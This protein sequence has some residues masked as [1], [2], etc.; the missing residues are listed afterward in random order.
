VTDV[1]TIAVS[2]RT[3]L[4]AG[5]AG[6][7]ALGLGLCRLEEK[8]KPALAPGEPAPPLV[9]DGL[10]DL[11]REKWSW[12]SVVHSSHARANCISTCSWNVFVKNGI[13]WR[14]EQNAIYEASEPGVP[15]FNPRGCQKGACYTHLM[16]EASRVTHPLRRVGERG[17]GRWKR[18]SWNEALTETADAI[19]DASVKSGTGAVVYDHGTT[20]IDFGPDTVGEMR[21]FRSL[22]ATVIDS[23]AGVGDMP[24]GAVQTWGMYNCEGTSDDWFKSDFIVVWVGNPAYTRI[25]EVHFK[26][27]ARYRGA[28][29]AVIAPDYNAS[30]VHA[31]YWLNPKVGTD[32]A[33]ALAMAQVILRES[34]HDVEYV[35]EQ[36]DLP[37][38]IREDTGRYLRE[39]DLKRNGNDEVLYFWDEAKDRLAKVP[40]AQGEGGRSLALGAL[41]PA[42]SGRRKVK[43]AD[44]S[45]VWVRPLLERMREHLDAEYTPEQSAAISGVSAG[46]IERIA[47]ELAAAGSAMIYSSW[48][49]CKHYH[50]DLAQR[51][52]ILLMALTGNQGKSGGGLRVSSWWPVEGFDRL[53]SGSGEIDLTTKVK[54]IVR[55][56]TGNLGWRELEN[57]MMSMLPR[58]G[59]TPL[60][61]FLYVHAGYKEI[62]DRK[63]WQDP[64]VPR[65]TAEY[66]KEAVDKGWIPIRP[67]PGIDPKVFIFTG[68][69]PL[70]RWPSPQIARKHLWPKLDWIVDVNFKMSTSGLNADLILPTAGYYER[71][72]LKYSQAY[73]PYLVMCEKAVEPL[74]EAKPEWEIF[75]L[76]ARKIQERAKERGVSVV[77]DSVG[78]DVDLAKTY[79]MWSDK[80]KLFEGDAKGVLD[81][82]LRLTSST[83]KLGLEASKATGMLPIVKA[84]GGWNPLYAVATDFKP[85][86]TLYP[87]ARMV[88][89]KEIWPT[90]TGRQ[91]FLIDH[92]WY[93]EV[94]ET[95]PVHK[96]PPR[97]GGD[98]PLR[99]TGGHTRW[100]IHATWR[101]S[102]LM[103]RLQRGEPALWMSNR[104]AAARGIGDGDRVRVYNDNG[105]FEAFAKL[106]GIVQPGQVV[107]Y[108]AW[109]PYQFKNWKGQA[110]P[111]AAP[112]KALHLAGGYG[113]IHYRMIYGAPSH[114][115]RGG[116]IEV[117]RVRSAAQGG[118]TA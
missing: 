21:L 99:L 83:G 60:M 31:D 101:D 116:T 95:L 52:K 51:A 72:S 40:G 57:L 84:S 66:M 19:I 92:A 69:N 106:A 7:A 2:R 91:Q 76:L 35:R 94:G 96:D 47:R 11:Y 59:S 64:A 112:W 65:S 6:V 22:N 81:K 100:S 1:K 8:E 14:E 67:E 50:S 45:Q 56:V 24:Y 82:L 54:A 79:D 15:D 48:G 105:E 28:K 32:A 20:N 61:P 37:V 74:G 114:S 62:W 88:E 3:F 49:A 10:G 18:V 34:L 39:S 27:E 86:K 109:E 9:Y 93:E 103:L 80:G 73:L 78:G 44:G 23:W 25:P 29:L 30:A 58:R 85:G 41:R 42:L 102:P 75:G 17:S 113:Q 98:Y 97:A 117:E 5:A 71:D 68:P 13:A 70:R 46:T 12:D 36:T 108:H 89:K 4:A 33:L 55:K 87:H 107:I 43:L 16:Y 115:P 104:D 38:L 110:E 90:L 118:S 63:D 111:V 77:R 26:H 53:A